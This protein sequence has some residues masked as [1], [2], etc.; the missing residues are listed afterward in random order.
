MIIFEIPNTPTELLKFFVDIIIIRGILSKKFASFIDKKFIT[1]MWRAVVR[2]FIKTD[3]DI[4]IW[5]HYRNR[6]AK[7]GHRHKN[8]N[9]CN[10]GACRL[11][12]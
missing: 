3:R 9:N 8:V 5:M 10:D 2:A 1:P 4:F 7:H 6:A 12:K 11:L